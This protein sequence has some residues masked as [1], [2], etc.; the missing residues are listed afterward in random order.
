VSSDLA[1]RIRAVVDECQGRGHEVHGRT[2]DVVHTESSDLLDHCESVGAVPPSQG[3]RSHQ[4]RSPALLG[5]AAN[6]LDL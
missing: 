2:L 6:I 1:R 4:G 3:A 5:G